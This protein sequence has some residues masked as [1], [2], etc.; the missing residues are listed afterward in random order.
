M[1]S[2]YGNDI[3]TKL[4]ILRK[5]AEKPYEIDGVTITGD[6]NL[7]EEE[8]KYYDKLEK[9][10]Q[11]LELQKTKMLM[12]EEKITENISNQALN[13]ERF[14][15][16]V[17][18]SVDDVNVLSNGM[19]LVDREIEE[20]NKDTEKTSYNFKNIG[21]G[22]EKTTKKIAKWALAIFGIR[23]VINFIKGSV[24]TLSQYDDQL[25]VNIEYIRYLLANTLKPII[26][27]LVGLA[28][29]LLTYINYIAQAWFGVNL[30]ANASLKAFEKQHKSMKDTNKQAKELQKT[31]AGFDEMNVLQDASKSSSQ[32]NGGGVSLPNFPKMEDVEIPDWVKWIADNGELI[33]DIIAGVGVALVSVKLGLKGIQALG[34]GIAG[35]AMTISD[36]LKFIQDP[37]WEGFINI[38]TDIAI[39]IGG[40]MLATGNWWGLL[41]VVVAGIVKLVVNNWGTIKKVLGQVGKWI[42]DNI[43][44]PVAKVFNSLWDGIK[45][46]VSKTWDFIKTIFSK[47]GK[48][49]VGIVEGVSEVFKTMVNAIIT[50]I[51]TV[52]AVPFKTIN[53]LLN[54]IRN[55][56]IPV[57]NV[58]PF[59]GLWDQDPLPIPEIPRLAKG[60]ILNN[61]GRGVYT[62]SAIAGE[63]GREL[64][65]PLQDEQMLNLIG[66][67][68]GKYI[69]IN[70]N[71]TNTMNG[72][73]ISR[74]LQKINNSVSFA[75]NR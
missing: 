56:N 72:R 29:K 7:S 31:L 44:K 57:I 26:E 27:T 68:I 16:K 36:I 39:A 53:G 66:E 18:K 11:Q 74:Q 15:E 52:I 5:K 32:T 43:I 20:T 69:T 35:V 25:A 1:I 14:N 10:L 50:G 3:Q 30:F 46:G 62:G 8:Q 45:K 63:A 48:I 33:A 28:Y 42:N 23:S 12:P 70:A 40:I 4:E 71:I 58:K 19:R 21:D 67:A 49:F 61:P 2:I 9:T 60:G 65:M 55:A 59:K 75:G 38:L 51:N 22:I 73:V 13:Q 64:Y 24:N 17:S 54:T 41:V 6:W 37:S 47:G 34:I